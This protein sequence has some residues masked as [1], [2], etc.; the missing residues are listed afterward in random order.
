MLKLSLG[1]LL[2]GWKNQCRLF[3]YD[4]PCLLRR[5]SCNPLSVLKQYALYALRL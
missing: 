1:R 5:L 3:R 4:V 2:D